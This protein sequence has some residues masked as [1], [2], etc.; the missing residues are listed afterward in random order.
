MDKALL[1]CKNCSI[2]FQSMN[3]LDQHAKSY[4]AK[5]NISL[6]QIDAVKCSYCGQIF[7]GKRHKFFYE[8][9]VELQHLGE[10]S[11]K[12]DRENGV[13]R[14]QYQCFVCKKYSPTY[15]SLQRHMKNH[16]RNMLCYVCGATFRFESELNKHLTMHTN[17]DGMSSKEYPC[18]H[19][20]HKF[21]SKYRLDTHMVVHTGLRPYKCDECEKAY[22]RSNMLMQHKQLEHSNVRYQCPICP[23]KFKSKQNLKK[24]RVVHT[25]EYPHKCQY[26]PKEFRN[27]F[28]CKSHMRKKHNHN[29]C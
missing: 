13:T 10:S 18:E 16:E 27:N 20:H 25:G 6:G 11:H 7:A 21:A 4:I 9:H 3:D 23:I 1:Y 2:A 14:L 28:N 12:L 5:R 19:C 24:H 17:G 15:S 29:E 26:C 8:Q 22:A